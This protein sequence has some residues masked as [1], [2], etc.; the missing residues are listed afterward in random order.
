[1]SQP[2]EISRSLSLPPP[3]RRLLDIVR[4]AI[5]RRH[6]SRRTEE[7]YVHWIRD[8]VGWAFSLPEALE[9]AIVLIRSVAG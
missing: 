7:T 5:R 1:M 4:E 9:K 8:I 6:D 2:P 3:G